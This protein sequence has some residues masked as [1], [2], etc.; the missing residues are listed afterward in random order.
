MNF[1]HNNNNNNNNNSLF[2]N[3]Q[4]VQSL[5]DT[6]N[7][8]AVL[9]ESLILNVVD[10]HQKTTECY[11]SWWPLWIKLIDFLY[12]NREWFIL[13]ID[14]IINS[15]TIIATV[16]AMMLI[17]T[18]MMMTT[19]TRRI[20]TWIAGLYWRVRMSSGASARSIKSRIAESQAC[21]G[22]DYYANCSDIYSSNS[23]DV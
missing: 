11:R 16:V 2:H 4:E 20:I 21:E 15:I 6:V 17:E 23:I 10:G 19:A 22:S 1:T 18:T 5:Q 7:I 14:I 13:I 8:F 12:E 3:I 9:L